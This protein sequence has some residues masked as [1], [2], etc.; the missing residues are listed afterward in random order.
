MVIVIYFV[1]VLLVGLW[2]KDSYSSFFGINFGLKALHSKL[3]YL[4]SEVP[5]RAF[6]EE[7]FHGK[8]NNFNSFSFKGV[9]AFKEKQRSF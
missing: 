5:R 8:F 2:V 3:K 4:Q 9:V 6:L 7:T 1:F